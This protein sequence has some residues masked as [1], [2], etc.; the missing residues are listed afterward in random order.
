MPT[1]WIHLLPTFPL[2]GARVRLTG[3]VGAPLY[4]PPTGN[5]PVVDEKLET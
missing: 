4:V 3:C 2:L 1:A 5:Q